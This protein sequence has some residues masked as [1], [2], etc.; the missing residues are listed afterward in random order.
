MI[1]N[2]KFKKVIIY[3]FLP[4]CLLGFGLLI[5]AYQIFTYRTGF[6]VLPYVHTANYKI[7]PLKGN[8]F[9]GDT[10]KGEFLAYEN[11]LGAIAFR[12]HN[13]HKERFIQ[14]DII[15]FRIKNKNEKKWF[16]KS[17]AKGTQFLELDLFP[18]GFPI[19]PNSKGKTYYFEIESLR[20]KKDNSLTFSNTAPNLITQY[21]FNKSELTSNKDLLESLLK[22][23][24][25]YVVKSSSFEYASFVY[26]LPFIIYILLLPQLKR[27]EFIS[28]VISGSATSLLRGYNLLSESENVKSVFNKKK[29]TIPLTI[30]VLILAITID[31][32]FVG[33]TINTTLAIIMCI[34]IWLAIK[35]HFNE[36]IFFF[37]AFVFLMLCPLFLI[38]NRY[39]QASKSATWAYCFLV[40]GLLWAVMQRFIRVNK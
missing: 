7:D 15:E 9:K 12:I 34:W 31:I 21:Q 25:A 29:L 3:F 26:L 10:I 5:I 40:L 17:T 14:E 39:E 13:F 2:K 11:N 37:F 32:L 30:V 24:A 36:R 35:Y 8:L 1:K 33:G 6:T 38:I 20:G 27:I 19:I 28:L 23:K 4:L 16:Y 22:N 18:F